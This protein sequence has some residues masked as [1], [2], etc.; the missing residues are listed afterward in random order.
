MLLGLLGKTATWTLNDPERRIEVV[1]FSIAPGPATS[2]LH[3][4]HAAAATPGR[5][6]AE[7]CRRLMH[8]RTLARIAVCNPFLEFSTSELGL[9]AHS[10][11]H[12]EQSINGLL[13]DDQAGMPVAYCLPRESSEMHI[14]F[15]SLLSCVDVELDVALLAALFGA[16]PARLKLPLRYRPG[17]AADGFYGAPAALRTYRWV[18]RQAIEK[19]CS[20]EKDRLRD[21]RFAAIMPFNAGDVLFVVLAMRKAHGFCEALVVDRRYADIAAEAAPELELIKIDLKPRVVDGIADWEW[22]LLERL[23]AGMPEGYVYSYCR[24]SRRYDRMPVH[25]IDQYAFGL[26]DACLGDSFRNSDLYPSTRRGQSEKSVLL[27]FD[28]GWPMKI[29]P[30]RL[31]AELVSGLLAAGFRVTV[32]SDREGKYEVGVLRIGYTSLGELKSLILSS[33]L[34]VGMDS[35]PVHYAAH[36]LNVPTIC[37]FA[38]TQPANSDAKESARYRALHQGLPCTP[39]GG[40]SRCPRFGGPECRNFASPQ[41]VCDAIAAMWCDV[42]GEHQWRIQ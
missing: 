34:V 38:S 13:I 21:L 19:I 16:S 8:S 24:P 14:P 31:Q 5:Y 12:T 35:F 41:A 36:L 6:L 42:Y 20:S 28:G 4:L 30:R 25:L 32:L 40:F 15:L 29:Y 22:A 33:S 27:H 37:L 1:N 17:I 9:L 11:M 3:L 26:G 39:C 18:A 10:L 7:M 23:E 2:S